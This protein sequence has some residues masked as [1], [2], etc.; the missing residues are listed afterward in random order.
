MERECCNFQ[1]VDEKKKSNPPIPY[2]GF[3]NTL[4]HIPKGKKYSNVDKICKQT[5]TIF[6]PVV[7]ETYALICI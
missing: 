5:I 2:Y 3:N 1:K 6:L 7:Y 4:G